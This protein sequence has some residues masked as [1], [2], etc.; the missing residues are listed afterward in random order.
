MWNKDGTLY[1]IP[2][3]WLDPTQTPVRNTYWDS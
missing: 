3:P 1:W 2:A